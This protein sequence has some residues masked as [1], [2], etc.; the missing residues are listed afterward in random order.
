MPKSV[1]D[2]NADELREELRKARAQVG[3]TADDR[4]AGE[5]LATRPWVKVIKQSK[6]THR[7]STTY[8]D[9]KVWDSGVLEQQIDED[10]TRPGAPRI[11]LI[12]EVERAAI[13]EPVTR[14]AGPGVRDT[15]GGR[16]LPG[17]GTGQGPVPGR[18][19]PGR[20]DQHAAARP[21]PPR[22]AVPGGHR[23]GRPRRARGH[24]IVGGSCCHCRSRTYGTGSR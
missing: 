5:I 1:N 22:Q 6:T 8:Q 11:M 21:A 15:A 18:G 13:E 23:A 10:E 3:Q 14:R 7:L 17:R 19:R 2:M 20:R 9:R 12:Q 24:R 16:C 4:T